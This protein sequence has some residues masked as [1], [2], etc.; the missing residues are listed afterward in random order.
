VTRAALAPPSPSFDWAYFF[1]LDGTLL[2]F[3]DV[4]G[5]LRIDDALRGQIGKLYDR[6]GG[7]VALI[8]GRALADIDRLLDG[9]RLP[10][11][12]QHGTERRDAR[13]RITHHDFP[14]ERLEWAHARLA[15]ATAGRS[16]LLVEHKGLSLALH[17]RRAPRLGGYAHRLVRSLAPKLGTQ[18]CIQPGKRIVEVKPAGKDKGVALV[19]FMAEEPFRGR[20]PI[21]VGDDLTDEYGFRAVNRLGGYSIKVGPGR[22]AARWRLPNVRAVREW[23][24]S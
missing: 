5:G 3:T 13:G 21:F 12:G 20:T 7:A 19:E 23:L 10:A 24:A 16:G 6:T 1:D 2:D 11:A 22:T 15:E 9:V 18:F 14:R 8:S 17:Y 4:P